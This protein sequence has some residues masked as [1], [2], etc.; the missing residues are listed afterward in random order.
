MNSGLCH[1]KLV[2]SKKQS[3]QTDLLVALIP[4]LEKR[5]GQCV[6]VKHKLHLAIEKYWYLV[7]LHDVSVTVRAV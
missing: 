2:Q 1:Q 6:N 3:Q 5:S 7:H 4:R